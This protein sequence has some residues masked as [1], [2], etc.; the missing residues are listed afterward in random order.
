MP[1]PMKPSGLHL[2]SR[3]ARQPRS[4]N[5]FP[6]PSA[7]LSHTM[8]RPAPRRA[9]RLSHTD[10]SAWTAAPS[11]SLHS[12]SQPEQPS[13][14]GEEGSRECVAQARHTLAV[15]AASFLSRSD[16]PLR[17]LL[18][19]ADFRYTFRAY[20]LSELT[21]KLKRSLTARRHLQS[22][23]RRRQSD[24]YVIRCAHHIRRLPLFPE[25]G[26]WASGEGLR[27]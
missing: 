19:Q 21:C 13:A 1:Q 8:P 18:Q 20:S 6:M 16:T 9:A 3:L 5:V 10:T 11:L 22:L 26:G 14:Q 15:A 2:F 25:R 23:C 4:A 24:R 27:R 7:A 17:P 12:R